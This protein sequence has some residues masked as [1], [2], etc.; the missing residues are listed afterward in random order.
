MIR[1]AYKITAIF[2]VCFF[3]MAAFHEAVPGLCTAEGPGS[4]TLCPFCTLVYTLGIVFAL[5]AITLPRAI[6][7]Y[8]PCF[9][10]PIISSECP[11]SLQLRGPP[12]AHA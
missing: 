3:I 5:L 10:A 7:F 9:A 12:V 6:Q 8:R 1:F 2:F 4:T 11:V